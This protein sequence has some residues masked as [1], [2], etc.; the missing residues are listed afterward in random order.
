MLNLKWQFY[1]KVLIPFL[2]A[3]FLFLLQ[4]VGYCLYKGKTGYKLILSLLLYIV[5]HKH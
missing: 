2:T 5:H 4:E 1:A 3:E